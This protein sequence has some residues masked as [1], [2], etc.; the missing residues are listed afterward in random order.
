[1]NLIKR[2]PKF[3]K[4]TASIIVV[5]LAI[6][7]IT[8]RIGS[9]ATP[10]DTNNP[11]GLL[12]KTVQDTSRNRELNFYAWYPTDATENVT[13]HMDNAVFQG[14]S[15]ILDAPIK[16]AEDGKY[17]LIVMSHGSGG[18]RGNQGWLAP[19]LARQG[20]IVVAANHPGSTS[21]DS[22]ASTNILVWNRPQDITFLI[23]SVLADPQLAP[24][25]DTDRIAV[26]GHS[27][28]GYTA[29]AIGGGELSIDQFIAYCD[30]F[31]A[32]PDCS[33][34][35]KG[36]V[37]LTQVDRS[38]FEQ[39]YRDERVSAV[40]VIDPAYAKSFKSESLG[41]R[42]ATLLIAPPFDGSVMGNL[43]VDYLADQID[44]GENYVL[45]DDSFH[46]T[47]LPEC[48]PIGFYLLK[49]VEEDG[50]V[51]CWPEDNRSRA[52][53]HAETTNVIVTFLESQAI[54]SS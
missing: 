6:V 24:M 44:S 7:A 8:F 33:F 31:P 2:T 11:V 52:E 18:N 35:R 36:E 10:V 45:I 29:F 47:F 54:F 40:V 20:A 49:M 39:S 13:M 37:D 41:D 51:L 9:P 25:I 19:E 48:K 43:Q 32:N 5:L 28:G 34:Y 27:L 17:P 38:K 16:G 21:M 42:A 23:D 15:A 46:F 3:V 30:E 22:A 26:I 12:D 50:E 53:L 14:F 1:M 4:I